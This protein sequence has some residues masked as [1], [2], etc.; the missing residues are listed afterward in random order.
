MKSQKE[1]IEITQKDLLELA[2][3]SGRRVLHDL[4]H[5]ISD[6]PTDHPFKKDYRERAKM[7]HTVFYPDNGMKNYLTEMHYQIRRLEVELS[8]AKDKLKLY[9]ISNTDPNLPF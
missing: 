1:D 8:V 9:G 6:L 2:I 4:D 3:K 7:W 5:V